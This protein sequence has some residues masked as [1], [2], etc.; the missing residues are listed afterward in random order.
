MVPVVASATRLRTG[1]LP[2]Q[3]R[4][5]AEKGTRH[6]SPPPAGHPPSRPQAP[7]RKKLAG[8][9]C[10]VAAKSPQP[11]GDRST[12]PGKADAAS[13]GTARKPGP[14]SLPPRG[15]SLSAEKSP[16]PTPPERASPAPARTRSEEPAVQEFRPE[17]S[18]VAGEGRWVGL[19]QF[20]G[21]SAQFRECLLFLRRGEV[22]LRAVGLAEEC[23]GGDVGAVMVEGVQPRADPGV[24]EARLSVRQDEVDRAGL[25]CDAE[26]GP[27]GRGVGARLLGEAVERATGAE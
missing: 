19:S 22:L 7:P 20:L 16:C 5:R 11:R 14:C 3:P 12:A 8:T 24:G 25:R 17:E 23:R 4:S 9:E 13:S 15:D 18:L 1:E 21:Q 10:S 6:P 27:L 2:N 26:R